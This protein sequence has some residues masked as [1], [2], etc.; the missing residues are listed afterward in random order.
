MNDEMY[1]ARNSIYC[2]KGTDVLKNKL[3]I[4]DLDTLSNI[5]RKLVLAKLY[6]LRQNKSIGNFDMQHF[7]FIH[8]FLFEDIYDFAGEFRR[9]NIAKDNFRFA[10]YEYIEQELDRLLNELKK[11]NYLKDLSKKDFVKCIIYYMTELN[12][13]H[14]FREGNGRTIREFI[15]ELEYVNGYIFNLRGMD[16]NIIMSAMKR[17]VINSDDLEKIMYKCIDKIDV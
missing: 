13:L 7:K 11:E 1:E 5:E 6:E 9:E 3:N 10:E 12:V 17:S 16:P 2:Y 15:R 8:R 4:H 14:P